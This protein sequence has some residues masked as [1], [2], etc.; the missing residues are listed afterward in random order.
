MT[1]LNDHDPHDHQV[2]PDRGPHLQHQRTLADTPF[3]GDDGQP[4]PQIRDLLAAGGADTQGYLRAI[5]GL[6]TVRLL[7]PVVA[8]ATVRGRTESGSLAE[9]E[10]ESDK[11]ADMAV[12]M[13][14]T[15]DGRTAMVAFTGLD[16]LTAWNRQARPV[17]VT[18]DLA[19]ASARQDGAEALLVDVGSEHPLAIDG[20]ILAELAVGHA[21]VELP[22]GQFGWAQPARGSAGS[23]R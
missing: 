4:D 14:Q 19:A 21:L 9:K 11:E 16:T 6:C 7:V 5:A 2:Q 8:T 3:A 20:Q 10:L 13:L 15:G 12:V 17:P 22:D 18:L 23:E 1:E